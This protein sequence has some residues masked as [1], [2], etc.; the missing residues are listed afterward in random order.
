LKASVF[1]DFAILVIILGASTNFIYPKQLHTEAQQQQ[2]PS[3]RHK[4]EQLTTYT[5][6]QGNY[7]LR[8]PPSWKV[9]YI[10]SVTL[11]DLPTIQ[12]RMQD[13]VSLLSIETSHA[14]L[15]RKQFEDGFLT[16]YPLI[17]RE[18]FNGIN[19]EN[20]TLGT[21]NI[22][23]HPAGSIVFSSPTDKTLGMS[24]GLFV[25]AILSNNQTISI[26]YISSNESYNNN[27]PDIEAMIDSIR[28]LRI[29]RRIN[30]VTADNSSSSS[31][32]I[33]Q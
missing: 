6:P 16:Y 4:Q 5:N 15:T 18:R 2:Q 17:L 24:K 23:G 31:V 32:S 14:E 3:E 27:I 22:D 12:F 11:H 7:T 28:A 13:S 30:S 19:I 10:K 29:D 8:Y 20:K 9:E 1:I 26:T 25:S 33:I 21:Y